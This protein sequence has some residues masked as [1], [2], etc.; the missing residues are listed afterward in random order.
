[1]T[2]VGGSG[3]MPSSSSFGIIANGFSALRTSM[4]SRSFEN[5]TEPR[6]AGTIV[7]MSVCGIFGSGPVGIVSMSSERPMISDRIMIAAYFDSTS[8]FS[9]QN[10]AAQQ[11]GQPQSQSHSKSFSRDFSSIESMLS[12]AFVLS[13]DPYW[14]P[15]LS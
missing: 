4:I 6:S 14:P 12:N 7:S 11:F 10:V 2:L 15:L 3:F 13:P 9:L 1:M 8:E 5:L